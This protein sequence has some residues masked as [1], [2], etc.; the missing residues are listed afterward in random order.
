MNQEAGPPSP[1]TFQHLDLDFQPQ[2]Y[3]KDISVG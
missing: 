1:R 3:N 2:N